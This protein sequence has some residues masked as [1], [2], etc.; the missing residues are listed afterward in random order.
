MDEEL[1]LKL[2]EIGAVK[3]G[4]FTLK[5][6]LK[7][8]I[9]ID[10]RVLISYPE[11]LKMVGK[12]LGDKVDGLDFDLVAGI[13]FAAIAIATAVSLEK[14]WR[15]VFPRKEQKDYGTKAKV[16]GKY[17]KGETC[18]V[19]DDL[20]TDG[21]SKFEAIAPLEKE[22]LKVKD[23]IVLVDREQGG[24]K[25]LLD[26]GYH[27]HSVFKVTELLEILHK[28]EKIEQIYYESA[29]EYFKDPEKWQEGK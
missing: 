10:L 20:I 25:T 22:G 28:H 7:S 24:K 17:S 27:L 5:S 12:A 3:F 19:I 9:Y 14:N 23:V 2:H 26:E 13:P 15:M 8:P 29:K 11:A 18:L 6:G 21:G 4:L 1:A 16:E